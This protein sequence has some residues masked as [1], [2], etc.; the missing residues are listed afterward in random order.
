MQLI[1]SYITYISAVRRYSERTQQVY[2]SVLDTFAAFLGATEDKDLIAGLTHNQLRNYEVYLMETRKECARTVGQ[3]LSVLS[4]FCRYLITKGKLQANPVRLVTRPKVEKRLPKFYRKEAMDQYFEATQGQ[5]EF[6]DYDAILSHLIISLLYGTGIRRSELISLRQDSVDFRR[7]VLRVRGKGDKVREIPLTSSL[8][9]EI[10][11]YLQSAEQTVEVA[12]SPSSPLLCTKKGNPL[13]PVFVDRVV[14]KEL[15]KA[16]G[17]TGQTSPHILRHT[18]ATELMAEGTDI[19]SIKELLGH[20]SLAATQVYT[21]NT[22]E[23]LQNI[24]NNAHPRAKT[25]GKNGDQN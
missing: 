2:R 12:A 11:L 17:I 6:G 5:S 24:Y 9:E 7:R 19:N 1:D 3:H 15:A 8:I 14:K 25:D 23:R 16:D 21:H 18:L 20:S 22:V 10:L 13:Y 4:G